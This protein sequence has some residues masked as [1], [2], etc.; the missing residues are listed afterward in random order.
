MVICRLNRASAYDIAK[1]EAVCNR[2]PWPASLFESEFDHSYSVT[3]GVRKEGLLVAFLV[4]HA[5]LDELHILNFGVEP[6]VRRLGIGNSL[7]RYVL[8]EYYEKGFASATLEVRSGNTA[9][10]ELY[11]KLGFFEIARRSKY[12]T[13]D[14][15]DGLVLRVHLRDYSRLSQIPG[16]QL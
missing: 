3:F 2:P 14:N 4:A 16:K 15:E 9:A 5:V 1:I 7:L 8:D 12:Y 11:R 13:D 6:A 10:Q